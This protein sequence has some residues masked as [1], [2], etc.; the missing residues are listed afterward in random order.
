MSDLPSDIACAA[1]AHD[2]YR[3]LFESEFVVERAWYGVAWEMDAR[4]CGRAWVGRE[5][6]MASGVI[7]V[8][9]HRGTRDPLRVYQ[10]PQI[11][12]AVRLDVHSNQAMCSPLVWTRGTTQ[13]NHPSA[14]VTC[15]RC[16]A[17]M[18]WMRRD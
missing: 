8:R 16:L 1:W 17:Q 13:S 4:R 14:V 15:R 12:H 7:A 11:R 6:P 9:S 2:T 3:E 5:V 10:R 18:R